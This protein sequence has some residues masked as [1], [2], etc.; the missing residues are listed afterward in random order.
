MTMTVT[1]TRRSICGYTG[2]TEQGASRASW[3]GGKCGIIEEEMLA[4]FVDLT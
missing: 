2:R 4:L 1:V 3:R